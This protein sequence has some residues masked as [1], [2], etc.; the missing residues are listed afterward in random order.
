MT[1]GCH[2]W[3][4][5]GSL[6]RGTLGPFP[7]CFCC[8][9]QS[10]IAGAAAAEPMALASPMIDPLDAELKCC[11]YPHRQLLSKRLYR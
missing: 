9:E 6:A 5:L 2:Y 7:C 4:A 3:S 10:H 1:S 11:Y 8:D